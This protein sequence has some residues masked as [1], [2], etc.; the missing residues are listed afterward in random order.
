MSGKPQRTASSPCWRCHLPHS[1][2]ARRVKLR[3]ASG[4]S[5]S[6]QRRPLPVVIELLVHGAP[7]RAREAAR[8]VIGEARRGPHALREQAV[9]GE[10]LDVEGPEAGAQLDREREALGIAATERFA[11]LA[12]V[13]E[14]AFG[15]ASRR[16][17]RRAVEPGEGGGE[18]SPG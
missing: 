10:A 5:A 4:S 9:V 12:W 17:R 11:E 8:Q 7:A 13:G 3:N 16:T 15:D 1:K 14:G 18:L 6:P 2:I